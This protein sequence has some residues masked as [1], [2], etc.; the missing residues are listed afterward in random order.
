[1]QAANLIR[2]VTPAYPPTAKFDRVQGIVIMKAVIGKDGSILSLE[3]INKLVD[4]RLADAAL[5][6]VKEWR[7]KPTL[8]NGE[9]IEVLT[10]IEVNFT[11]S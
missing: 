11:L 7:Y 1:M 10:E 3:Q 6:A 9:P 8:L 2:K 5:E 4:K